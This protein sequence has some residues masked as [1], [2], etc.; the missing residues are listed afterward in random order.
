MNIL[1]IDE[2]WDN[3]VNLTVTH[4][5]L[6]T[7]ISQKQ[8][9]DNGDGVFFHQPDDTANKEQSW[10]LL[11]SNVLLRQEVQKLTWLRLK[12]YKCVSIFLKI[13]KN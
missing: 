8:P 3:K 1:R 9:K 2:F 13:K 11:L 10:P 12:E 6:P 4:P 5:H 7:S